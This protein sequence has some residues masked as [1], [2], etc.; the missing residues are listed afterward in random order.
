MAQL[1]KG[2]FVRGYDKPIHGSCDIYFPGGIAYMDVVKIQ[3]NPFIE[4]NRLLTTVNK[5]FGTPPRHIISS[6]NGGISRYIYY[7]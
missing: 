4:M 2:G 1:P 5:G 7:I 6:I 3:N